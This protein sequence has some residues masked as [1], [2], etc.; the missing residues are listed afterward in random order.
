MH[1]FIARCKAFSRERRLGK[2]FRSYYGLHAHNKKAS[3]KSASFT[4]S[5]LRQRALELMRKLSS[6]NK[7][8][9]GERRKINFLPPLCLFHPKTLLVLIGSPGYLTPP[10]G[11]IEKKH[12]ERLN[13]LIS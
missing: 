9:L 12:R 4:H 10:Y 11:V 6:F 7:L 8:F 2:V 3:I 13:E 5:P 1:C